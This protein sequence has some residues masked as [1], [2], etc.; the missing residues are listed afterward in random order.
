MVLFCKALGSGNGSLMTHD[1]GW[2]GGIREE[3]EAH[4]EVRGEPTDIRSQ[5]ALGLA[6]S[7]AGPQLYQAIRTL[8]PTKGIG[9]H[10]WGENEQK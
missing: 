7:C 8:R 4:S 2:C 3:S 1:S 5:E 6:I 9:Q 10:H